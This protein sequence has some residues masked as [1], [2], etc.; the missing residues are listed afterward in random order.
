MPPL[1]PIIFPP[2][3]GT[4]LILMCVASSLTICIPEFVSVIRH[5]G[6]HSVYVCVRGSIFCAP[7]ASPPASYQQFSNFLP[8]STLSFSRWLPSAP[9]SRSDITITRHASSFSLV[10][11]Q[12]LYVCFKKYFLPQKFPKNV[13]KVSS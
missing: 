10:T 12:S 3:S 6:M 5:T 8:L 1:A 2:F 7:I 4:L 13:S 9:H 11:L